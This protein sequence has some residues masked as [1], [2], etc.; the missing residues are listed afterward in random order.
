MHKLELR[1]HLLYLSGNRQTLS[2]AEAHNTRKIPIEFEVFNHIDKSKIH[3][4]H[5]LVSLENES[6]EESAKRLI[7]EAGVNL[8][9][10]RYRRANK[11]LAIEWLFTV[12][13]GFA[14]DYIDLY[15]KSLQWLI[16]QL[17]GCPIAHAIIHFDEADPHMHVVMIPLEG[18]R[19][20][21]SKI[22]GFKGISR[23]RTMD[24]YEKVA[25]Q[26]GLSHPARLSGA[27]K[28]RAAEITI[29][30]CEKLNYR[31]ILGRMWQ[32]IVMAIRS[33]PEPFMDALDVSAD[34]EELTSK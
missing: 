13:P 16:D 2:K 21:A 25:K 19:L 28:R 4:N 10:G 15:S 20:P 31:K 26:F 23:A 24:L 8:N 6:L 18:K 27:A 17:P 9:S 33:R 34:F 3:L 1:G 22:L 12:T 32:P 11:G 29:K 30:V 7:A 14:C 5:E